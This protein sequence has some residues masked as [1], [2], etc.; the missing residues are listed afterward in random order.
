MSVSFAVD[1]AIPATKNRVELS[2]RYRF[3]IQQRYDGSHFFRNS[4]QLFIGTYTYFWRV[5]ENW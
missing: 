3:R 5:P 1:L 4:V 2:G